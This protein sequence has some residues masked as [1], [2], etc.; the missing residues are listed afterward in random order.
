M[1]MDGDRDLDGMRL[2]P[3]LGQKTTLR[4]GPAAPRVPPDAPSHHHHDFK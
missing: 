2:D 3:C 1:D 4:G